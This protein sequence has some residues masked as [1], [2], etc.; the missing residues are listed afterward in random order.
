MSETKGIVVYCASS[1]DID[2]KYFEFARSVGREIARRGYTLVSGGGRGGLMAAAID[3]ALEEGGDTIGV[4][5]DFMIERQWNHRRL[6][7]TL[8]TSSMHERKKT[9]ADLSCAAIAL[10]GGVGTLDELFEIITWRQLGLYKGN[11]VIANAYGF[12]DLLLEHLQSTADK[13]FMRSDNLWTVATTPED[14][15]KKAVGPISPVHDPGIKY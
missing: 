1:A 13:R 11:V 10:P 7:T 12:Y 8:T 3:G 6:G 4:L 2:P 15:V 9:M 14:A 5:P